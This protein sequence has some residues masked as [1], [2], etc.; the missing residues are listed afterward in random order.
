M[1]AQS[2][3]GRDGIP[4]PEF[5]LVART[6]HLGSASVSVGSVALGGVTLIGVLTG[7]TTL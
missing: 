6:F 4:I 2:Q 1:A 5:G 3:R 7:I